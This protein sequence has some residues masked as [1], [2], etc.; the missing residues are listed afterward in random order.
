M[1]S[2]NAKN[3]HYLPKLSLKSVQI[4]SWN[5]TLPPATNTHP[6]FRFHLKS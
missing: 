3:D 1:F 5:W 4:V 2:A 6:S